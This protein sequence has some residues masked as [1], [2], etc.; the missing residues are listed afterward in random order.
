MSAVNKFL[1]FR[2]SVLTSDGKLDKRPSPS[3][4]QPPAKRQTTRPQNFP[5]TPLRQVYVPPVNMTKAENGEQEIDIEGCVE[6]IFSRTG[7]TAL[8]ELRTSSGQLFTVRGKFMLVDKH[9]IYKCRCVRRMEHQKVVYFV[10]KMLE[11]ALR[12]RDITL[13][14]LRHQLVAFNILTKE[15]AVDHLLGVFRDDI[16]DT[17]QGKVARL[18]QTTVSIDHLHDVYGRHLW[19]ARLAEMWMPIKFRN[20][21]MLCQFWSLALLQELSFA[22]IEFVIASLKK[23]PLFWMLEDYN[24]TGLR[25]IEPTPANIILMEQTLGISIPPEEPR[26]A[27]LYNSI[28]GRMTANGC[29]SLTLEELAATSNYHP[30]ITPLMYSKKYEL[31]HIQYERELG[32]PR[33]YLKLDHIARKTLE[34]RLRY[35]AGQSTDDMKINS[36]FAILNPT[37]EQKDCVTAITRQQNI[38]LIDGDPGTGKSEVAGAIYASFPRGS[39]RAVVAWAEPATRQKAKLGDGMTIDMFLTKIRRQTKDGLRFQERTQVLIIDEL[40]ICNLRKLAALLELLPHL[41]KLIMMGDRKQLGAYGF[42]HVL[43]SFLRKWQG[44]PYVRTLTH[45]FRVDKESEVLIHNFASFLAGRMEDIKY[46]NFL[47]SDNPMKILQRLPIPEKA[48]TPR[49]PEDVIMRRRVF[50]QEVQSIHLAL[51]TK[52]PMYMCNTRMLV[53]RHE[54]VNMFN[55]AWFTLL[56]PTRR[57]SK[58]V[59][60][61]G[62]KICFKKN[63]NWTKYTWT[64][65]IKCSEV[66]NNQRAIIKE[67]Y[68]VNPFGD[69]GAAMANRITVDSTDA[70]MEHETWVRVVRCADDVQVNLSDYHIAWLDRAYVSTI[71]SSI[72]SETDRVVVYVHPKHY[73]YHRGLLYTAMTRA[74]KEVIVLCD[75]GTDPSLEHS[76]LKRIWTD[77]PPDPPTSLPIYIPAYE[78]KPEL[79]TT[80]DAP[81]SVQLPAHCPG[82]VYAKNIILFGGDENF[83]PDSSNIDDASNGLLHWQTVEEAF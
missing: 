61:V 81:T 3:T 63:M 69:Q 35:I 59:F 26:M 73:Y 29:D 68:D 58:S 75:M 49:T 27:R 31:L 55:E 51:A 18:N 54:D 36:N 24:N 37:Q 57:Y 21:S 39:V 77:P 15:E 22:E 11:P 32:Q 70:K 76:D 66:T 9:F 17:S 64:P 5:P 19:Y 74:K 8:L 6:R 41:R 65:Q 60:Y 30:D 45:V 20:I 23:E 46:A 4:A 1:A 33:V 16:T 56:Y 52:D 38:I 34:M 80:V 82:Q 53:Q 40:G 83:Q 71:A 7:K 2:Q 28:H 25:F 78:P 79:L 42:G 47:E 12:P 13:D 62:E 50:M 48:I 72:G 14:E 43:P 10:T 44:T 67:I